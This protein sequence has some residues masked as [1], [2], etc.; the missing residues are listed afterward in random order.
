MGTASEAV[1]LDLF[2]ART[3][4]CFEADV[5]LKRPES[6]TE[7]KQRKHSKDAEAT[8]EETTT[9]SEEQAPSYFV[10]DASWGRFSSN[11]SR[12]GDA[13]AKF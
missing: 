2:G 3:K 12:G 7:I 13:T 5:P 8:T 4:R 11:F 6:N 9:T 10:P 1:A